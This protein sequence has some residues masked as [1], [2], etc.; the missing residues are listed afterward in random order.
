MINSAV[1]EDTMRCTRRIHSVLL[2]LALV[3]PVRYVYG[4][5]SSDVTRPAYPDS[6]EGLR[7]QFAEIVRIARSNDRA[8]FRAEIDSLAI[9]DSPRWFEAHFDPRFGSQLPKDY[10]SALASYQSHIT[11]VMENFTKFADFAVVVLPLNPPTPL[12]ESG[13]ESLLPSPSNEIRI[14]DF[15]LSSS[16]PDPKHGPPSW[17]SSFVY[18]DGRFRYVGGTYPFWDEGLTAL[19]GPMSLPPAI[20]HGRTVQ[21]I[22]NR[23]DQPGSGIDAVVQLKVEIGRDGRVRHIKVVSGDAS[24]VE[25]AEDYVKERD[26][27]AV[28]DIPQLANARRDWE[29][30]IAFFTPKK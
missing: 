2:V 14:E 11:W 30:E 9:P 10:A 16:A 13:F 5:A 4:Q 29:M 24:F 27:G 3:F 23:K 17:V 20:I 19:R 8:R 28:P 26:F 15:R 7:A 1:P 6:G 21:G 25:D 18:I 12:A 22:A